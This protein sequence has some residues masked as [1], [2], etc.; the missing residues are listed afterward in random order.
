MPAGTTPEEREEMQNVQR[1]QKYAT[2]GMESC[3]VKVGMSAGAGEFEC[4]I[5]VRNVSLAWVGSGRLELEDWLSRFTLYTFLY[6]KL[7]RTLSV[8]SCPSTQGSHWEVSSLSCLPLSLTKTPYHELRKSS[9]G[10][11]RRRCS[12]SKR[13]AGTCGVQ[14]KGSPKSE[15]SIRGTSVVSRG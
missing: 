1:W 6:L 3:P 15:R 8:S 4:V 11:R 14:G 12:S 7:T 10:P 5:V 13:W 2:M 9:W